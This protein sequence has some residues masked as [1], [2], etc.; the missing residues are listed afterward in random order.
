[1]P[2]D[3]GEMNPADDSV[4]L[5]NAVLERMVYRKLYAAYSRQGRIEISPKR[6]FKILVYGYMNGIYSGRKLE[7]ACRRDVNFM[8]LLGREKAPAHATITRFRSE[9]LAEVVDDL[10]AQLIRRLAQEGELSLSSVFIDG[11]KLEN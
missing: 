7:Q 8:Y 5:L 1:M 6:L 4:R 2:M 9:R 3:I 11:T 10:F